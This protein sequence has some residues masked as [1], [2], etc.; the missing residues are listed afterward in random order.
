MSRV[1]LLTGKGGVGKTTVAAATALACARRGSRVLVLSTDPAHSLADAFATDLGPEPTVVAGS[2][3]AQQLDTC[4]RLEEAWGDARSWLADLLAWLGLQA[5]EAEE[6]AAVPGLDEV[7][8]LADIRAHA[9]SGDWDVVVVDC[10]PTAETLRLLSLPEILAR[11]ADRLLPAGQVVAGALGPMAGR[12]SSLPVPGD[13]VFDAVAGLH[14]RLDGVRELLAD[15]VRSS[16]RLVVNP[17]AMVVAEARRTYTYLSLFGYATDAVVVNRLLP[18]TVADPWFDRW[19]VSQAEHLG[20]IADAF[21][22]LPLLR[23]D[24][25]AEEVRGVDRLARF[26]DA[27]YGDT[28]PTAVLHRSP[29][30]RVEAR[31]HD[32]VLAV[33]LPLARAADLDVAR[34]GGELLVKVGSWRRSLVLP[35]SLRSRPTIGARLVRDDLEV[36]FGPAGTPS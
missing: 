33:P 36:T 35:D 5:V 31:G 2:L 21:G 25:A 18:P 8:A 26:A 17:E 10:A 34:R 20:A 1:L 12:L 13:A 4:A 9:A 22:S 15:P 16:V 32:R 28:D 14:A 29:A 19:R 24:L 6:L 27:L 30:L 23:A 3:S 7:F 11:Y